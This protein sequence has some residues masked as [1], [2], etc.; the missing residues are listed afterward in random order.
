MLRCWSFD[1][2]GRPMFIY[3]LD[4]LMELKRKT[5]NAQIQSV[6]QGQE[7]I[8]KQDE[9]INEVEEV[10]VA[11]TGGT[12]KY[13]ELIYDEGYE[14]PRPPPQ[15]GQGQVQACSDEDVTSLDKLLPVLA[16]AHGQLSIADSLSENTINSE[17]THR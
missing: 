9:W 6:Q 7:T 16:P 10:N 5:A 12:H 11:D 15:T 14:V 17:D 4:V 2:E 8:F 3:C 1:P 13:L